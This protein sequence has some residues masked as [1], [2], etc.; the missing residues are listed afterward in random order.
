[1]WK[2]AAT[3]SYKT[4]VK[5]VAWIDPAAKPKTFLFDVERFV[6][7]FEADVMA[8]GCGHYRTGTVRY[9]KLVL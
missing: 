7:Y 3:S 5:V 2:S 8:R 4:E 9:G 1:M 6:E